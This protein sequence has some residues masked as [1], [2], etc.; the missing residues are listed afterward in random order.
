VSIFFLRDVRAPGRHLAQKFVSLGKM[1]GKTRNEI[2]AV[3]GPPNSISAMA[4]GKVLCQWM[5]T[6]YHIAILFDSTGQFIKITHQSR[7]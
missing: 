3:V 7:V 5:A 1:T 6:G 2:Q 4:G